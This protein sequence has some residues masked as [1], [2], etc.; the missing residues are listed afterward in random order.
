MKI[1]ILLTAAFLLIEQFQ[2]LDASEVWQL[3]GGMGL[4]AVLPFLPY[5]L[6]LLLDS[7]GWRQVMPEPANTSLWEIGAIR[8]ATDAVMNTFPAG[9][10][11]SETL[12]PLLLHRRMKIGLPD[13]VAATL[14]SKINIAVMQMLFLVTGLI[15]AMISYAEPLERLGLGASPATGLLLT[16]VATLFAALMWLPYSGG[17]LT[18]IAR[19]L[20]RIPY[21]RL[22]NKL[23]QLQPAVTEIDSYLQHLRQNRVS[24]LLRSLSCF[25]LSWFALAAETW[26]ILSLLGADITFVQA[27]IIESIAAGVKLLFFFIPSGLGAQEISFVALVSALAVPDA[28]TISAA[29]IVL[30]RGKELA[31]ALTGLL[32]FPSLGINPFTL[33]AHKPRPA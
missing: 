24:Y 19:M 15:L 23:S 11:F 32:L 1:T 33:T 7:I 4:L 2:S 13:A 27:I 3:L 9:V 18:Q 5:V 14:V 28:L 12:R 10:A 31:W 25:L 29:F 26:L 17:R 6:V 21:A 20:T 22:R 8:L 30:R 16:L